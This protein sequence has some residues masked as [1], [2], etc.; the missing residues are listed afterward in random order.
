M[1]TI[2]I[3]ENWLLKYPEKYGLTIEKYLK[4]VRNE[5]NKLMRIYKNTRIWYD[6][7]F[8]I[9]DLRKKIIRIENNFIKMNKFI[10]SLYQL[11]RVI[12]KEWKGYVGVLLDKKGICCIDLIKSFL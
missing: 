7:G 10:K 5:K 8:I 12:R 2:P 3:L 11:E 1:I 6:Y 9:N 4:D